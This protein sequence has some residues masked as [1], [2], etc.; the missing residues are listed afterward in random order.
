M[1]LNRVIDFG[2][3]VEVASG[4]KV[5]ALATSPKTGWLA[6]V[7]TAK[8]TVAKSTDNVGIEVTYKV[9]DEEAVDIE[10]NSF[11]GKKQWDTVWFSEKS[12]KITKIKLAGL[13]VDVDNL[14]VEDEA[15]IKD[16][17]EALRE[18]A[19]LEVSLVTEATE[20]TYG[21]G[22]YEDGTQKYRSNVRFVNSVS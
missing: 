17:A 20:D 8:Y 18:S 13:G 15:D 6:E 4:G 12:L 11:T 10:D 21:T 5:K 22:E 14:I 3:D 2:K 9:T 16:L 19:G 1:G 7:L